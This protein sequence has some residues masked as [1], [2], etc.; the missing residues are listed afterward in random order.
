MEDGVLSLALVFKS[1]E[2]SMDGIALEFI[3]GWGVIS[4]FSI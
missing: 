1:L 3:Y 2:F 4:C